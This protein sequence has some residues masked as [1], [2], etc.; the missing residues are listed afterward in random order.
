MDVHWFIENN[1][2]TMKDLNR[3]V[4]SKHA[5]KWK[6]VGLELDLDLDILNNIEI[7]H[8]VNCKFCF[9]NTL[10]K[11]L[12]LGTN[13]TWKTLEVALTNVNRQQAG[14][15]PVDDVYGKVFK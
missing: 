3:Y 10:Q 6:D 2:P 13:T 5:A 11:W 12:K 9:Q 1:T 14:L 7:D 15:D 4:T 8:P